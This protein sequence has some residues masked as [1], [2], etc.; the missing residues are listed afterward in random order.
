[1]ALNI[2]GISS[3]ARPP[4]GILANGVFPD[5]GIA[6]FRPLWWAEPWRLGNGGFASDATRALGAGAWETVTLRRKMDHLSCSA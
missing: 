5:P 1:M 3:A 2:Q 4:V 6:G